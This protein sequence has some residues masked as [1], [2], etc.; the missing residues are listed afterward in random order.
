MMS[1]IEQPSRENDKGVGPVARDSLT[2]LV[3]NNLRQA[4]MEGRF[5][6]GHRFKIRELAAAMNV[7][8][9]PIRE[10]LMQLVRARAL[11]MQAGKSIIVAH[12]TAKQYIELRTVRL[13]LEGLAA[14]H[15]TTRISEA[16][17]DRIEVVHEEL[18]RAE[19]EGRWPDAVR[20]NWQFHRGLYDASELPEVLAILDD[21]WMRNG[22][23]LN[24]HYPDAPPTYPKEH[25]HLAV[26]KYLRQR[27][28][29]KVRESIQA[30]MMEGGQNLVRLLEKSGGTR[31]MPQR[32]E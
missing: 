4:L 12:M 16:D 32:A 11:E 15:A 9:T 27:R 28:P 5:W 17:I 13:F 23:L 30:D 21:I 8:E 3:Y 24:F 19:Q 6:P 10:A 22:P 18:I 1:D 2:G 31:F 29:D 25:Q 7:S 14:E 20:A 26:L